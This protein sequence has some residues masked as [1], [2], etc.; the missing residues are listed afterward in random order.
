MSRVR[1]G[2]APGVLRCADTRPPDARRTRRVRGPSTRR[3]G[4][5]PTIL[6]LVVL[7]REIER[8]EQTRKR[9]PTQPGLRDR[10]MQP[11][12]TIRP[13]DHQAVTLD[14]LVERRDRVGLPTRGL[15]DRDLTVIEL[16]DRRQAA[17][18][19]RTGPAETGRTLRLRTHQESFLRP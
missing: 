11:R 7:D 12:L 17:P 3:A 6:D 5:R 9:R 8:A 10:R 19:V 18:Q 1:F 2:L 4:H 16:V 14:Q 13:V 15:D